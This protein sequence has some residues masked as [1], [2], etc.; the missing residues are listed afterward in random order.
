M[1]IDAASGWILTYME[2]GRL[3]PVPSPIGNIK[4]EDE[5]FVSL[6]YLDIDEYA[7]RYGKKAV[8]KNITIPAYLNAFAESQHI[9]FS[10]LVHDALAEK[11]RQLQQ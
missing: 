7:K 4:L 1:G 11:S 6:I 9:N 8:R 2:E 10:Q 3:I 5:G